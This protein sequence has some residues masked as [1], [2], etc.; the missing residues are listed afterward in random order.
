MMRFYERHQAI[1]MGAE[2]LRA[3]ILDSAPKVAWRILGDEIDI[4]VGA[5]GISLTEGGGSVSPQDLVIFGQWL[6]DSFS[7][8]GK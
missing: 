7:E 4:H 3:D 8:E 5:G 1:A 2:E 6:V